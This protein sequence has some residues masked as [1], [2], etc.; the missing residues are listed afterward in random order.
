MS[1]IISAEDLKNQ[2]SEP[3][4][5]IIDAQSAKDSF[6]LFRSQHIRGAVHVDLDTDLSEKS[7]DPANGGRHPLPGINTFA[8]LVGKLGIDPASHVVVYDNKNG[9]NAA[10]RFWWMLKSAGHDKV[11]VL[12]GGMN[13]AIKAGIQVTSEISNPNSK[14]AYPVQ[15]WKLPA[16]SLETVKGATSDP[17][18]L[19][20]DVREGYRYRGEK[21]P[22][23][24]IAGH[25]PGAVNVPYISN[26]GD[27][28][29]FLPPEELAEIYKS[30]IGD[31]KPE[32][33][34]VSCGSG[35]TA[36]HT[37]LAMEQAGIE[38]ANLYV[39]SWSE[40]SRNNLP[41]AKGG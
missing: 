24:S 28:G 20:I 15:D 31:R 1:P 6:E 32:E 36:C 18:K 21:E 16:V 37:L 33:V 13:A 10:A 30:V 14:A 27:D 7:S 25:I 23:D 22:L 12:D 29:L 35:I 39:G 34:I 8:S 26:L 40:W 4:L 19:I 9:A 2:I 11:Q 17:N 5:V 38:G 41:I 3:G